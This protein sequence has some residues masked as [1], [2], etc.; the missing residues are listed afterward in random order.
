MFPQL[1]T[2]LVKAVGR[3]FYRDEACAVLESLCRAPLRDDCL[4]ESLG[5]AE[6]QVR[7]ILLDLQRERLVEDELV[8]QRRYKLKIRG[9]LDIDALRR[10]IAANTGIAAAVSGNSSGDGNGS[11]SAGSGGGGSAVSAKRPREGDGGSGSSSA[12]DSTDEDDIEDLTRPVGTKGKAAGKP[13]FV[14]GGGSAIDRMALRAIRSAAH[15]RKQAASETLAAGEPAAAAAASAAAATAVAPPPLPKKVRARLWFINPRYFVDV[16]KFRVHLLR[17]FLERLESSEGSEAAFRCA[18]TRLCRFECTLLEA[19]QRLTAER[20][21][22]S[23]SGRAA[24]KNGDS[25]GVGG[26]VTSAFCGVAG[27]LYAGAAAAPA[28]STAAYTFCCP[29]C[30]SALAVKQVERIAATAARAAARLADQ[31]K[32]L[33]IS[34]LLQRLERV[35]LGT[36]RPSELLREGRITLLAEDTA[37]RGGQLRVG[38][39]GGGGDL[40]AHQA[41]SFIMGGSE[42]AQAATVATAAA[43]PGAAPAASTGTATS[44]GAGLS[45]GVGG[46]GGGGSLTG[47]VTSRNDGGGAKAALFFRSGPAIEVELDDDGGKAAAAAANARAKTAAVAAAAGASVSQRALP[48]HLRVSSVTGAQTRFLGFVNVDVGAEDAAARAAAASLVADDEEEEGNGSGGG[49]VASAPAG[50]ADAAVAAATHSALA[51]LE[52]ALRA[53]GDSSSALLAPALTVSA[54]PPKSSNETASSEALWAMLFAQATAE[55]AADADHGGSTPP[56]HAPSADS[57]ALADDWEDA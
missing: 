6:R 24:G 8:V 31:L 3:A 43:A 36:V 1:V 16:V 4:H 9:E 57:V 52:L 33:G 13:T 12:D 46:G 17:K 40:T 10:Q 22:R 49:A 39:T 37:P 15:A 19:Q 26:H 2:D 56:P 55:G 44:A 51:A 14:P 35:R 11:G 54:P 20:H 28:A 5:L 7:K 42:G 32:V 27:S 45:G 41:A 23:S 38:G 34:E 25:A 30:G 48:E 29:L 50:A 21:I 18:N 53:N 47:T